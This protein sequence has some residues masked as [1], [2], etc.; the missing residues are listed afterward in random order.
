M[1]CHG[2]LTI[3]PLYVPSHV[4]LSLILIFPLRRP[5]A[6]N[7]APIAMSIQ[8]HASQ[9]V[10]VG[11]RIEDKCLIGPIVTLGKEVFIRFRTQSIICSACRV[12]QTTTIVSRDREGSV[13]GVPCDLVDS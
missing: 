12:E 4:R 1:I 8:R 10:H 2:L 13:T 9:V 11:N 3:L 5:C 7:A 6:I